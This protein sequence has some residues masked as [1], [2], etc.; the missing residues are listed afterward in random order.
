MMTP[1]TLKQKNP[2]SLHMKK[3]KKVMN[4]KRMMIH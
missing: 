4:T 2:R 3:M 1:M